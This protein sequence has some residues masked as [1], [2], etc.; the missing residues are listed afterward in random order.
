MLDD[1]RVELI[2]LL[3]CGCR[4]L[5]Q[6]FMTSGVQHDNTKDH[7]KYRYD[8]DMDKESIRDLH[9]NLTKLRKIQLQ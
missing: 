9:D 3:N 5:H 6:S 7:I 4:L 1:D 2:I 8:I